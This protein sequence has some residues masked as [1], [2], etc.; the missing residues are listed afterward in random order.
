MKSITYIFLLCLF[1]ITSCSY[2][3]QLFS[4]QATTHREN[5]WYHVMQ[6]QKDSIA[7]E[8]IITVKDFIALRLD[9][10]YSGKNVIV[11]QIS[12]HKLK[13]W[14]DETEKAIGQ[15]IV[16]LFNDSVIT[17]PQ[18]NCRLESGTFQISSLSD[19]NRPTIFKE[20][21]KEKIDSIEALFVG[22]EKDSIYYTISQEQKD[23][24]RFS[25]DYWEAKGWMNLTT[26]AEKY[27]LYDIQ[28]SIEHKKLEKAL[29]EERLD[30]L[31]RKEEI[32]Q[33]GAV[34]IKDTQ[35]IHE[36]PK[37]AK[38]DYDLEKYYVSQ[39]KYPEELLKKNVA[40]HSVVMFSID[41][42]GLPREINILTSI[43]KEFD[44]EVI[45]L[46]KELPHC[47]PCRDK[48]GK[49]MECLYTVYVPFLPQQ[50]RNRVKAD[51]IAEEE[52]KYCFVEWDEQAK[53]QEGKQ[54]SPQ[55]Y[56]YQNLKYDA[57][58]L[59]EQQKTKGVY[60][61]H[62]DSYGEIKE[63]K[64]LRSCG[65]SQWDEEVERIIRNMPRWTPTIHHRGKGGYKDAIWTIP[66]VFKND[67]GKN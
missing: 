45:R 15:R 5:G 39:M 66:V 29:E 13:I 27:F 24:I 58:L 41:T 31:W 55:N 63:T 32:W 62:I 43:H 28:D 1:V 59:D 46:T 30:S 65:I 37:W 42:L 57:R 36:A 52:L 23:S 17:A 9:S 19:N 49:R 21:R 18:V 6:G 60:K 47:L 7:H 48:N 20:L 38:W 35:T 40:G 10:D 50:Y 25:I 11:G 53:F 26:N 16:F 51:S 3:R 4:S 44:T 14:G 22:W 61:I 34:P 33:L 56:I 67:S 64:T 54:W 12:K 2:R 8:P